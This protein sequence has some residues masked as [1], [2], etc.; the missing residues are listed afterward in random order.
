MPFK[1]QDKK[2][3]WDKQYR[4][5]NLEKK[6]AYLKEYYAKNREKMVD[7][8]KVWQKENASKK[9]ERNRVWQ[10]ENTHIVCAKEAKR[11]ATKMC[12]TPSWADHGAIKAIYK[13]ARERSKETG[14]KMHVDHVIPL[15]GENVCGLHVEGNLQIIT[16]AENLAKK[17]NFQTL[18]K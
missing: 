13:E 2:R 15:Q 9:N 4:D 1:D 16:A 14:L 11:R 18:H 3:E 10:K 17:N 7:Q 12:A 6:K 5:A 8:S